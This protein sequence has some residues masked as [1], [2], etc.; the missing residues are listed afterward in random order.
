M[1][2]IL[3]CRSAPQLGASNQNKTGLKICISEGLENLF[4]LHCL[5]WGNGVPLFVTV[6]W[7]HLIRYQT[8]NT[9][10]PYPDMSRLQIDNKN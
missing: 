5:L 6:S 3:V 1:T 4:S 8:E 7:L 9:F 2:D 10:I